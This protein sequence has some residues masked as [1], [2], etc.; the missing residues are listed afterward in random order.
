M[1]GGYKTKIK[2]NVNVKMYENNKV[3][4]NNDNK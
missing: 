3:H 1:C 4:D 2:K